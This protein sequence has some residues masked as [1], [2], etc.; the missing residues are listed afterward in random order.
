MI[1]KISTTFDFGK[2]LRNLD[3]IIND[4]VHYIKIITV[5]SAKDIIRGGKLKKLSPGT[6]YIRR[7]GLSPKR[8]KTSGTTP[9]VHTGNLLASIKPNKEGIQ[10]AG[11][12]KYHLKPYTI[13]R[14]SFTNYMEKA[15][16]M[17][18]VGTRVPARNPFFTPKGSLRGESK[19]FAKSS[20][21]DFYNDINRFLT[22]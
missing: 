10:M 18:M 4:H 8:G 13:V 17:F 2:L 16:S 15:H 12:G 11:Y 1:E 21:K 3:K 7:H 20:M 19:R 5:D 14:N 22:K 9:L 6:L